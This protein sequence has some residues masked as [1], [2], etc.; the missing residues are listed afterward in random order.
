[1]SGLIGEGISPHRICRILNWVWSSC[2]CRDRRP[3]SIQGGGGGTSTLN[4]GGPPPFSVTQGAPTPGP[5]PP[6]TSH[7]MNSSYQPPREKCNTKME[8]YD[9]KKESFESF[10]DRFEECAEHYGWEGRDK[11]FHLKQCIATSINSVLWSSGK[12]INAEQQL[13]RL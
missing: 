4:L 10:E 3:A 8:L 5:C 13:G 9:P 1:M 11:L 6:V 12:A 2:A 7:T